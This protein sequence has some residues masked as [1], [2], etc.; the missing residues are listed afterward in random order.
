MIR[1][2]LEGRICRPVDGGRPAAVGLCRIVMLHD[3]LAPLALP[4]VED[5]D[6]P[7]ADRRTH[8][9]TVPDQL[10]LTESPVARCGAKRTKICTSFFAADQVGYRMRVFPF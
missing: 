10:S 3:I 7:T 6:W 4:I 2:D 9:T 1:Q 5:S 8:Q